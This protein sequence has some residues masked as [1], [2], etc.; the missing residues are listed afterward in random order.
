MDCP[1]PSGHL[2]CSLGYSSL[3][4]GAV[5]GGPGKDIGPGADK[6]GTSAQRTDRNERSWTARPLLRIT[7]SITQPSGA[8]LSVA[9]DMRGTVPGRAIWATPSGHV[10]VTT[11]HRDVAV[12]KTAG[13]VPLHV[14]AADGDGVNRQGQS[15]RVL[16]RE[17][18]KAMGQEPVL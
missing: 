9:W 18:K 10:K 15:A 13:S 14:R 16:A 4:C 12:Y 6:C 2:S 17:V 11:L 3:P 1:E 7:W 5:Q 8:S